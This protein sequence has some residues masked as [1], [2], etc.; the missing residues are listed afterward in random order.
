MAD[1]KISQLTQL[2]DPNGN[3][4]FVV[5]DDNASPGAGKNKSL[6]LK[7][8][9]RN[10]PN[11]SSSTPSLSFTGDENETG[12]YRS[13]EDEIAISCNNSYK[14]KFTTSGFQ[15]GSGTP[16]AP[17]HL[18]SPNTDDHLIVESTESNDSGVAPNLVLFRNSSSPRN[19]D[20]LGRLEFRGKNNPGEDIGYAHI[21]ARMEDRSNASEDGTLFIA[22]M[23]NG[24]AASR[25]TIKRDNVGINEI[26]P[27]YPLH[28]T[29][30]SISTAL[31]IESEDDESSSAAD[32]TLYHHR[33]N[34]AGQDNDVLS[35]ILFQGN[36][37]ANNPEETI[38]S[39]ISASIVDATDTDEMGKI[40]LNV[41]NAGELESVV[42][43]TG[44]D[45]TLGAPPILPTGAPDSMS[46]TGTAGQIAFG[47]GELYICV[48]TNS[49]KKVRVQ[50]F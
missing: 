30:S 31:F 44:D 3:D 1:R 10:V 20:D 16:K 13:G 23:K 5:V 21:T 40:D 18:F 33:E 27:K 11:G 7:T 19:D 28:I 15:I 43:V 29:E 4:L 34:A 9:F 2:T 39:S 41:M 32:I 37:D 49:W 42:S 6:E 47:N 14:A 35:S 45:I 8:L 26:S 12:F 36:N 38:F 46:S 22:T 48:A 17:F 50:D 24:Y 25:I